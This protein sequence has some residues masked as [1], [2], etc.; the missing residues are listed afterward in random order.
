MSQELGLELWKMRLDRKHVK[1]GRRSFDDLQ[2]MKVIEVEIFMR[3]KK[4]IERERQEKKQK[5]IEYIKRNQKNSEYKF[6]IFF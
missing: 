1:N 6:R 2:K 5:R 3:E 4:D